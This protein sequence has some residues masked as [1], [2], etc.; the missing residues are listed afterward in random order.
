M[1]DVETCLKSVSLV[2]AFIWLR[3]ILTETGKF[4][5]AG[6]DFGRT[7]LEM[8][9]WPPSRSQNRRIIEWLRLEGTIKIIRFQPPAMGRDISHQPRV[10]RAPSNLALHTARE[11]AATASLGNLGQGLTTLMVKNFLPISNLNLPSPKVFPDTFP[12]ISCTQDVFLL[13][14][15][16][17]V[18]MAMGYVGFFKQ[19]QKKDREQI[20]SLH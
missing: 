7:W 17:Q 18:E 2:T 8:N 1:P 12:D 10:L 9:S 13:L 16:L 15:I 5:C 3:R 20:H 19:T 14:P 4:F 11:G 6:A